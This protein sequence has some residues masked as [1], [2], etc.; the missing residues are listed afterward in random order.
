[1]LLYPEL[2]YSHVLYRAV[3]H[4]AQVKQGH[5]ILIT[6][7]GGRFRK[8]RLYAPYTEL[9]CLGGVATVALQLAVAL[10]ANVYVTR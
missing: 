4:Q 6:G 1:M 10:G 5:N 7:I 3:N 2:L 8:M 9:P